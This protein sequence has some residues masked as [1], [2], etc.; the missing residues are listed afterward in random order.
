[1]VE[2]I[3]LA[4][5]QG[6]AYDEALRFMR[7]QAES[8]QVY[9]GDV[10]VS[11]VCEKAEGVYELVGGELVW[12]APSREENQHVEIAVQDREDHRFV[13]GL[14]VECDVIDDGGEVVAKLRPQFI[15][16]PYLHHYGAN[17]SLPH[18]G[19]FT[20]FVRIGAPR[21]ARHDEERGKRYAKDLEFAMGP[22]PVVLGQK[23]HGPE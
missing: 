6:Q 5:A 10:I 18:D 12:R 11:L 14:T 1:M 15:W 8:A 13:P 9:D 17:C 7:K 19:D 4:S 20:F 22:L 21:F 16:H 23:P 2:R 3:K